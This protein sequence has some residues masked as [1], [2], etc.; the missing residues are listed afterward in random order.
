VVLDNR[1]N[2]EYLTLGAYFLK[3]FSENNINSL[4]TEIDGSYLTHD[5]RSLRRFG[6]KWN[7]RLFKSRMVKFLDQNE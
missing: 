2:R 1:I 7:E 5:R 3:T 4:L 6:L